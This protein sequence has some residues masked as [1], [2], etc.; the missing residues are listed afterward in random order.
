MRTLFPAEARRRAWPALVIKP[1]DFHVSTVWLADRWPLLRNR[2][3]FLS[4]VR[5]GCHSLVWSARA[6]WVVPNHVIQFIAGHADCCVTE[7]FNDLSDPEILALVI[8]EVT[9]ESISYSIPRKR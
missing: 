3:I 4:P 8:C 2:R 9:K 7:K 1:R 5:D 6:A